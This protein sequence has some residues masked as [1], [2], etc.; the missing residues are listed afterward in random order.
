MGET[1][2][3]ALVISKDEEE[4]IEDCLKSLL[5]ADEIV[6]ID[7]GSTDGT[8]EI[9]KSYGVRVVHNDWPGYIGQRNF[10][11]KFA[12]GEW[13]LSLDADER[14][15]PELRDEII[16]VL[17]NP[18][19]D[20]YAIPRVVFYINRWIRHCGWYPDRKIRLFKKEKGVW[21]GENPHDKVILDGK[22]E[23]LNGDLY[24]LSFDDISDHIR[25][26][27]NFTSVAADE[28]V[29]KGKKAGLFAILLRPPATFL[30]MYI[31]KRGFLDGIPGFIVSS[32]SAWHVFS[33][34]IKIR[35]INKG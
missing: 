10:A 17:K 9:A 19:A 30:K 35:E 5:F 4:K 24:H 18:K 20:G 13:V 34:Y 28:R 25:T 31:L 8:I 7:S 3:T 16:K 2:L 14:V 23:N 21:G 32:L 15:S 12:E 26:I 33:K 27:Q 6:M 11:K 29:A 1:R 22:V